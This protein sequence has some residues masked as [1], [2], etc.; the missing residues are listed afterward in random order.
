MAAAF[1]RQSQLTKPAGAL[2]KLEGLS[3]WLAGVQR[4]S[5]PRSLKRKRLVVFAGDH[6]IAARGVSAY[7]PDVTAQMVRN[8]V[9]GGA[10]ANVLAGRVGV[11][12][13]VLDLAVATDLPDL[14]A[15]V[16]SHKVRRGSGAIDKEPALPLPEAMAAFGAGVSIA[17][18]EVDAGADL[19]IAGDMGIGNSTIAAALVAAITG[20]EPV[21]V[22]GRGT[23]VDDFTWA[24]KV[25][26]VR[27]A[28]RRSKH[29]LLEPVELLAELGGADVAAMTGFLVGAAARRTPVVLDGVVSGAAALV[30]A[31]LSPG[32][33]A[34]F[35][36]GHRSTEPAHT[37]ALSQ[38]GLQPLLELDLRLGEGTGALL[39]V[40]LLDAAVDILRDMA[41]FD[42]AGVSG[43]T[44]A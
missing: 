40:P 37:R 41:T 23:G 25:A 16:A 18:E 31:R 39:A 33:V 36:A 8:L 3:I 35:A 27:D 12:L 24:R 28:L 7:P 6:G 26:A 44:P 30:A 22:V 2:G 29:L 1:E 9:A 13:R 5:P 43:R 14:P 15:D 11:G 20:A 32:A 4:V 17:D 10:A 38:L 42:D 21:D 34:Y 19:L